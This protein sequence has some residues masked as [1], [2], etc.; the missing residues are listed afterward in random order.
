MNV[1]IR[2]IEGSVNDH[3]FCLF[4]S[5]PGVKTKNRMKHSAVKIHAQC[6]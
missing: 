1:C 6:M 3:E 5:D 4:C 2:R